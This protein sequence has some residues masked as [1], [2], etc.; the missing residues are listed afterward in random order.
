M[1]KDQTKQIALWAAL[2][3]LAAVA[4]MAFA[5]WVRFVLLPGVNPV[6]GFR[7]H[8]LW[9]ALFAPVYVILYGLL[10][11]YTPHP[12]K[13]FIHD[14]G[15][16][17]LGNTLGVM[18]YIDLIFVFRV[19]DFSRW[20]IWIFYLMLNFLTMIRGFL[21]HRALRRRYRRGIGLRRLVIVGDGPAAKDCLD[22]IRR[23]RDSGYAVAGSVGET[24]LA[25]V[26]LLGGYEDI[27]TVLDT[28]A[29]DR[30]VLAL[31]EDQADR[32][33]DIL[34]RCEDTGVEL[35]LLPIYYGYMSAR[36]Y[37]EELAGLPLIN[38]RRVRLN[39]TAADLAKRVMDVVGS[40]ALIV[41]TSPI[42]L[43]A[44]VGTAASSPGPVIFRQERIGRDRK[45]FQ[46]LKFRSMRLNDASDSAWTR[47][48]DPRRTR[49]GAFMRRYSIDELPQ[50][51]NVLKG[52]MSLVGPRP[53]IPRY[54][55]HFKFSVPLYMVRHRVRPGITGWA[56]VNGL[57][58]DTSIPERVDY[59]LY[60]IE[61]WSL[62]FDLKILLLTPFRGI[63]NRQE[64]LVGREH[65]GE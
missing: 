15:R 27:R 39:D 22:R 60:Y 25:G 56:Q 6:G 61:N 4:A 5:Y 23:Q 17:V 55:D 62:L 58:G 2:D 65:D 29:P 46:M 28:A 18:A 48:G 21:A 53:E 47:D 59:D 13:S 1:N 49:F 30:V 44:A 64:T 31:E 24:S 34:R 40:L 8:M 35:A 37:M 3:L 19:V 12:Q 33:G 45:P 51:F 54:V 43:L 7:Y 11:V 38:I 32:L 10:G 14:F 9:G 63:V 52:D 26:P 41:L 20:M 50:L 16:I 36:P 57:R 42:M